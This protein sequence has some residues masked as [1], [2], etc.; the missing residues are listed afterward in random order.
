M[1][2]IGETIDKVRKMK[3]MSVTSLTDDLVS[4]SEYYKFAAGKIQLTTPI[5]FDI[6]CR[7]NVSLDEFEFIYQKENP[8]AFNVLIR[9]MMTA[10]YS[11]DQNALYE[12]VLTT[13]RLYKENHISK[14][15]HLTIMTKLFLNRLQQKDPNE[16]LSL[17]ITELVHYFSQLQFW[18][19]YDIGLFNNT[20]FAL[21][22]DARVTLSNSVVKNFQDYEN[23]STKSS[24]IIL[25]INNVII[26]SIAT[27]HLSDVPKL[28]DDLHTIKLQDDW[29][30]ERLIVKFYDGILDFLK[31]SNHPKEKCE[32][33]VSLTKQIGLSKWTAQFADILKNTEA[34]VNPQGWTESPPS[35]M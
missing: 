25:F 1:Q 27:N 19:H 2:K 32:N 35:L 34:E 4:R 15:R 17:E 22:Q 18:T 31:K 23:Y 5:F 6:L 26:L 9:K 8:S 10:F 21:P 29:A 13:D 28:V 3:G 24:E 12:L 33:V 11:N 14:F 16:L 30:L 20:M 7:L